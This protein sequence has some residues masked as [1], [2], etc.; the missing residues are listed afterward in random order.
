MQSFCWIRQITLDQ[1]IV[2]Q[3]RDSLKNE[4][5]ILITMNSR[6]IVDKQ[7]IARAGFVERLLV[8]N[9]RTVQGH[10]VVESDDQNL[11]TNLDQRFHGVR[12]DKMIVRDT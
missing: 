12:E 1:R 3:S 4:M 7:I 6:Q 8:L 10:V 9:G 5:E 2:Q 11:Q